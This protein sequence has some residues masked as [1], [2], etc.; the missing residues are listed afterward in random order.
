MANILS[1]FFYWKALKTYII[2]IQQCVDKKLNILDG[3]LEIK[4]SVTS[5]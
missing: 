3:I 1:S 2:K 4:K 5:F